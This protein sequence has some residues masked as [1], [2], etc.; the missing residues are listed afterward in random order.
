VHFGEQ[1]KQAIGEKHPELYFSQF[2]AKPGAGRSQLGVFG[3]SGAIEAM[4]FSL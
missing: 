1:R 3:Y 2:L 4:Y